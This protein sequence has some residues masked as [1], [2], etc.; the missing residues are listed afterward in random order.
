MNKTEL[1]AAVAA[2]A[3]IS[4]KDAAQLINFVFGAISDTVCEKGE[5]VAI[6]DF[7]KFSLKAVPE[8]KGRNPQTGEE[9][10]IPAHDK[11]VFK[12]ATTFD[13]FSRKH[14]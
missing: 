11:V 6:P 8:R 13:I 9:L 14:Y 3:E 1:A 4:K 10:T 7:G 5:E 2:R 12:P